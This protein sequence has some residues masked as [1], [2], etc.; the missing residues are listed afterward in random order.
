V[1]EELTRHRLLAPAKPRPHQDV[2]HTLTRRVC[3]EIPS[4]RQCQKCQRRV[5]RR[6]LALLAPCWV[7]HIEISSVEEEEVS[8]SICVPLRLGSLCPD[9]FRVIS[10]GIIS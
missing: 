4:V 6:L 7:R 5:L 3:G 1:D 9:S 10:Q 8:G 2:L